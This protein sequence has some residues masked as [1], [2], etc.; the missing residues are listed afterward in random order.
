[1]DIRRHPALRERVGAFLDGAVHEVAWERFGSEAEVEQYS[2][3]AL[4]LS[5]TLLAPPG[6][7]ASA[8]F[9]RAC[10]A[11]IAGRQRLDSW[12]TWRGTSRRAGSVSRTRP[13][14]GTV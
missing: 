10:L 5:M 12:K 1:M 7:A 6:E 3:P 4:M 11:L 14:P 8:G 9:E 2:L 13:W